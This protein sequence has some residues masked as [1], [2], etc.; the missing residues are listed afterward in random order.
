V[1]ARPRL[2]NWSAIDF[3][4]AASIAYWS[5]ITSGAAT[6][7]GAPGSI[8]FGTVSC[9]S[10]VVCDMRDGLIKPLTIVGLLFTKLKAVAI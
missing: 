4:F 10:I 3:F 7:G 6:V 9:D 5:G 1:D 8:V 2:D